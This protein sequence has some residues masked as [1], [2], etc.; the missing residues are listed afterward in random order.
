MMDRDGGPGFRGFD[1][2][3]YDRDGGADRDRGERL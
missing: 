3:R 2:D 1:R